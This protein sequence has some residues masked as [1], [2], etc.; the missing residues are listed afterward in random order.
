MSSD[1]LHLAW[2]SMMSRHVRVQVRVAASTPTSTTLP[3]NSAISVGCLHSYYLRIALTSYIK[4]RNKKDFLKNIL[5]QC[6]CTD[7][8]NTIPE[9]QQQFLN[10]DESQPTY[11]ILL[12]VLRTHRRWIQKCICRWEV[13]VA[14]TIQ[15]CQA[16]LTATT[17]NPNVMQQKRKRGPETCHPYCQDYQEKGRYCVIVLPT[18]TS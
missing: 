4:V 16:I 2:G 10:I 9:L 15:Q 1:V 17:R 13:L 6:C 11:T 5:H 8:W 18:Y 12:V 3:L 7:L 14:V